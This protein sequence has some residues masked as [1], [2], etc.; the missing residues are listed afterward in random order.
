MAI[1]LMLPITFKLPVLTSL[2]LLVGTYKGSQFGGSISAILVGVPGTPEASATLLDGYPMAKNGQPGRALKLAL[3]GSV[4]ADLS[5]DVY[6]IIFA[7]VLAPYALLIGPAE[8][9]GILIFALSLIAVVASDTPLKGLFS[10]I[11]GILLSSVGMDPITGTPRFIFGQLNLLEGISLIPVMLGFFAIFTL[12]EEAENKNAKKH[13]NIISLGKKRDKFTLK[14]LIEVLPTILRSGAI[15]AVIGAIPGLG[16]GPA[17]FIAY[18]VAKNRSKD[19][20][21]FGHGHPEGVAAAE[22]GNSGT[23]GATLL[24]VL[25]LGVPGSGIAALFMAALII[26]GVE[27]GPQIFI[28]Y[29]V[30]VYGLFIALIIGNFFNWLCGEMLIPLGRIIVQAK[31][32]FLYPIVLSL[33]IIGTY[34][35]ANRL[36][37]V[38]VMFAVGVIGYFMKK[39]SVPVIPAVIGFVLGKLAEKSLRQALLIFDQNAMLFLENPVVVI[40]ILLSLIIIGSS[41]VSSIKKGDIE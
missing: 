39:F 29:P 13:E 6:L 1:A 40:C 37:D 19:K 12:I 18:G 34:G 21:K 31:P 20:D 14:D 30:V 27:P 5:S 28:N 11:I 2:C 15:G 33:C 3:Y 36:F 26:Q 38:W 25:I 22:A 4:I 7:G 35:V 23:V 17:A 16:S 24:P 8:K 9:F 10:A 41:F 32:A